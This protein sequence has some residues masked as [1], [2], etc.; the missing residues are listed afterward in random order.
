MRKRIITPTPETVRARAEGWL[1]MQRVV[2]VELTSE[3]K[4]YP[5]ESAFVFE[6]GQGRRAAGSGPQTVRLIFDE[7]Q[8]IKRI[9]L[10]FEEQENSRTQEFALRFSADGGS[11]FKEIV[12]QQWNF[13][14]PEAKRE[15]EDYRVELLNATVIELSIVPDISGG[16]SRASIKNM[17]MS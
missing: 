9:Q 15:T 6:E 7:P 14:P 4:R 8:T 17:R 10:I 2:T 5:I 3:G 13:N 16:G 12:R 11:S 1:D